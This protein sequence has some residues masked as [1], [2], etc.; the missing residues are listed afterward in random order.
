MRTIELTRTAGAALAAELR[1][2]NRSRVAVLG[3]RFTVASR[4]AGSIRVQKAHIAAIRAYNRRV[5]AIGDLQGRIRSELARL[6][7]QIG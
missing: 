6:Q 3:R 4:T 1:Q 2:K 7:R 5:G